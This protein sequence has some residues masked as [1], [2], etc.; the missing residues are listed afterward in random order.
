[1]HDDIIENYAEP[2][3]ELQVSGYQFT[4]DID[5]EVIAHLNSPNAQAQ[6]GPL[7]DAVQPPPAAS[8]ESMPPPSCKSRVS[9]SS[10][11]A[12]AVLLLIGEADDSHY[13]GS[14]AS[15]SLRVARNMIYLE[16]SDTAEL[17]QDSLRRLRCWRDGAA[18]RQ[19]PA[20]I[21]KRPLCR[22]GRTWQLCPLHANGNL[23]AAPSPCSSAGSDGPRTSAQP[24]HPRR[25]CYTSCRCNYFRTMSRWSR[26]PT[27]I[28]QEI[29]LNQ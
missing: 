22:R 28:S 12:M 3:A 10:P 8:S 23:R 5:T 16:D 1:V 18:G 14:D 29:W 2:K 7:F 4:S 26:E 25:R 24:Q 11:P 20:D 17:T 27:W 6:P 13:A 15:A 9:A 19:R 21:P